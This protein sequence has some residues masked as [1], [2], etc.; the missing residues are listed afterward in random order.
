M[1]GVIGRNADIYINGTLA[2]AAKGVTIGISVELIKDY[3]IGS[4]DPNVLEPGNRSYPVS[5]DTLYVDKTHAS[6]VHLGTKITIN[7]L[8]TGSPPGEEYIY[9]D[10]VLTNWE[11][12]IPQDGVILETVSGEGKTIT[13]PT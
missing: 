11:N 7:V 1:S 12:S 3:V 5:I 6:L 8:P 4:Q 2:G 10:V 13:L 9:N